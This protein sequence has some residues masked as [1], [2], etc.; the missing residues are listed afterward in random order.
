MVEPIES[1]IKH[2]K[3]SGITIKYDKYLIDDK[4]ITRDKNEVVWAERYR[5]RILEDLV[6]PDNMKNSIGDFIKNQELPN[7]LLYSRDG[8]FGKD[9]IISVML[10][11]IPNTLLTINASLHRDINTIRTTVLEF[12]SRKSL[13]GTRKV[14]YLNE[15]GGLTKIAL[16]SIKAIIEDYSSNVAFFMTTNSMDNITHPLKSR[17]EFYELD[18]T[19]DTDKHEMALQIWSRLKAI[20][21]IEE[22]DVDDDSMKQL[23][24]DYFPK[25]RD[26]LIN[27]QKYS[28]GGKFE[29]LHSET[30][31][32]LLFKVL[33]NI[34]QSK[35]QTL[36]SL[37]ESIDISL[38]MSA[39]NNNAYKY[40]EAETMLGDYMV[41]LDELQVKINDR[42]PFSNLA[43][44][45][46]CYQLISDN[47]KFNI[48]GK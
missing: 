24:K 36:V 29:I 47:I 2:K 13:D 25:F 43:F 46:F 6:L 9:S 12:A 23:L 30:S 1:G 17:F 31:D 16:D 19:S 5:P 28:N 39:L 44:N 4:H 33:H 10:S 38:I 41:A 42:V 27:L 34:N 15:V 26:I 22:I 20:T 8:G 14:I 21:D 18:I 7:L 37:G 32:E 11:Q 45:V 3:T 48:E 40:L 35:L